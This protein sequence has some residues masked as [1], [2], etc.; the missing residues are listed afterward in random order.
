MAQRFKSRSATTLMAEVTA[1]DT[2]LMV[3]SAVSFPT[4]GTDWDVG[5]HMY[6]VLAEGTKFE[7]VKITA[8]AGNTFTVERGQ[9]GFAAQAFG[10]G[11]VVASRPT[12]AAFNDILET[13]QTAIAASS[14]LTS[15]QRE[16][17]ND[18]VLARAGAVTFDERE[19]TLHGADDSKEYSIEL[20][21]FTVEGPDGP[22]GT[23]TTVETIQFLGVTLTRTGNK[24]V[25]RVSTQDD[26]PLEQRV[27][28]LEGFESALRT[29][30]Q[31]GSVTWTQ[32][33]SSAAFPAAGIALPTTVHDQKVTITFVDS[34]NRFDFALR[35]LRDKTAVTTPGTPLNDSNSVS[36]TEGGVVYRFAHNNAT[37]MFLAAED[38]A[39]V[40]NIRVAIEETKVPADNLPK[41]TATEPGIAVLAPGA[42][43][44]STTQAGVVELADENDAQTDA[45]R[46]ATPDLVRRRIAEIPP[47]AEA[48]ATPDA[49]TSVKGKIEIATQGE[50]DTGTDEE[51]A[52]TPRLVRREIDRSTPSDVP[53]DHKRTVFGVLEGDDHWAAS[54]SIKVGPEQQTVP[55]AGTIV[56][57]SYAASQVGGPGLTTAY[58]PIEVPL[59]EQPAIAAETARLALIETDVVNRDFTGDELTLV[60]TSGGNAYYYATVKNLPASIQW[61]GED[62]TLVKLK[63]SVIDVAQWK[64]VLDSGA[65]TLLTSLPA[66]FE[67]QRQ[68]AIIRTSTF[69]PWLDVSAVAGGINDPFR[70]NDIGGALAG[71][72]LIRFGPGAGSGIAN[73]LVLRRPQSAAATVSPLAILLDGGQYTLNARGGGFT[74]DFIVAGYTVSG[75]GA[76]HHEVAVITGAGIANIPDV[77]T[78]RP[79]IYI[80]TDDHT[81]VAPRYD[82]NV[83]DHEEVTL[84]NRSRSGLSV[85]S[86]NASSVYSALFE[87]SPR[88][89]L[90][91][92]R[93][94]L[95][96]LVTITINDSANNGISFQSD[97]LVSTKTF[98]VRRFIEG[99][100]GLLDL[101]AITTGTSGGALL[102]TAEVF[103]ESTA[104]KLGEHKFYGGKTFAAADGDPVYYTDITKWEGDAGSYGFSFSYSVQCRYIPARYFSFSQTA[105][106]TFEQIATGLNA[107]AGA[108]RLSWAALRGVPALVASLGGL[109]TTGQ[110]GKFLG[111]NTGATA[112]EF[113]DAPSGATPTESEAHFTP[114]SS[115]ASWGSVSTGSTSGRVIG[116][117]TI[118][119]IDL[120]AD[121]ALPDGITLA[122]NVLTIRDAGRIRMDGAIIIESYNTAGNAQTAG[123]NSRS[124]VV[125]WIE[126]AA[127]GS[128]TWTMIDRSASTS[129]YIRVGQPYFNH[130]CGYAYVHFHAEP[131][132]AAGDRIRMRGAALY[133]Q[134]STVQHRVLA[135]NPDSNQLPGSSFA[136]IHE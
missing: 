50:A 103:H 8:I 40:G 4:P 42:A 21:G 68:Y 107:L 26:A 63:R 73:Q 18:A 84:F 87:P 56:G 22:I 37:G 24:I 47:P 65:P 76:G 125:L 34:G 113:K 71:W 45:T 51:R 128:S 93:G 19:M 91:G 127:S 78:Y 86:S 2:T 95:E 88:F 133:N 83:P 97:R 66:R 85:I 120:A 59:A 12:G 30:R 23:V 29:T 98:E 33:A 96:W 106:R 130:D 92:K 101:V 5:D 32:G 69:Q 10:V 122:S 132:V 89:R 60:T 9:E 118:R 20:P 27:E 7:V 131:M 13:L 121:G 102:D 115:R 129:D 16:W 112:L 110:G 136:V 41:A 53:L 108:A 1:A 31:L 114:S 55:T 105:Q 67:P 135:D 99:D 126:K 11:A 109:A 77:L 72:Q 62:L 14:T 17:L 3:V 79:G 82:A 46:A 124:R 117:P 28:D 75:F 49:S 116:A 15:T 90:D 80:A 54:A 74:N 104:A 94:E 6:V 70:V 61:R 39:V 100:G 35:R 25:V 123:N 119:D 44:A 43:A 81:L 58:I 57:F 134:A 38:V 52:M 64:G 48:A 111:L 36:F